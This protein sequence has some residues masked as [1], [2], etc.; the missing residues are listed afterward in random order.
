[1]TREEAKKLSNVLKAYSEG[2]IIQY[3]QND[4]H[5]HA[6]LRFYDCSDQDNIT[7]NVK[8]YNYR[9]KPEP[10]YRPF[11]NQE[12]CWEEMLKHQPFG[13]IKN[14]AGNIFN[15]IVMFNNTIKLNE[16]YNSYSILF[17]GYKF[18]DGAPFGIKE[19]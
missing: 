6:D 5:R 17:K 4:T 16:C 3:Q 13:Y 18:I 12:E 8:E 10:E 2:K 9:I 15:I 11:K 14:N 1:M 19:E 7:F